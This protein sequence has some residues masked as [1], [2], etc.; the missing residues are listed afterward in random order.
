MLSRSFFSNC[1]QGPFPKITGKSSG[2][3]MRLKRYWLI[4]DVGG[5]VVRSLLQ[6]SERWPY[7]IWHVDRMKFALLD[8]NL[9][10]DGGQAC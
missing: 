7:H 4:K 10:G 3:V 2:I 8:A 5:R 6:L 1:G 9:G